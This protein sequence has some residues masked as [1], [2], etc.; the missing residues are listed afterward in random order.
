MQDI[1]RAVGNIV[2]KNRKKLKMT[3]FELANI[4]GVDPKYISRIETGTSYPSLSVVEKIFN[5]LNINIRTLFEE[6][7]N[8]DK[9]VLISNINDNL[10][11][12]TL[13]NVQIIKDIVE[14]IT[15]KY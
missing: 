15:E 11:N 8:I 6:E 3:Q 7:E 1:R 9:T 5:K 13:K 10:K 2:K 4:I 14:T 12:T